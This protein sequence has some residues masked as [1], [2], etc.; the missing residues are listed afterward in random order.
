M[1][2]TRAGTL[3]F[4]YWNEAVLGLLREEYWREAVPG[5]RRQPIRCMHIP[6]GTSAEAGFP[7]E[8]EMPYLH[9]HHRS[10]KQLQA[11]PGE[12]IS[13]TLFFTPKTLVV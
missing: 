9:P 7:A 10:R 13:K 2:L 1:V 6:G 5:L 8:H 12:L 3:S 4:Q 11:I